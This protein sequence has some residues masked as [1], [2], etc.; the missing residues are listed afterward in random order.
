LDGRARFAGV[1]CEAQRLASSVLA[2][3]GECGARGTS[4]FSL[5]AQ[6]LRGTIVSTSDSPACG[7]P[8]PITSGP[9]IVVMDR[10]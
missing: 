2:E 6:T 9:V 5:D 10:A 4:V 7:S 1:T 3:R 8:A